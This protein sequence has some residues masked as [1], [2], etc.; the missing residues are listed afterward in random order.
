MTF[1]DNGV[2]GTGLHSDGWTYS[3]PKD[4]AHHPLRARHRWKRAH[5]VVTDRIGSG[6]LPLRQRT[7]GAGPHTP[8][9][10]P[11][12]G[13]TGSGHVGHRDTAAQVGAPSETRRVARTGIASHP[14]RT[15]S[16]TPSPGGMSR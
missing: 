10:R 9:G 12:G 13:G 15:H 14:L 4:A 11:D 1:L 7:S 6:D 2:R 8:T 3:A 5:R 16:P